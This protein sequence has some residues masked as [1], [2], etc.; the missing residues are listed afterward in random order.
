M[1]AHTGP[2][3]LL[4]SRQV[5]GYSL[6]F[7]VYELLTRVRLQY[8]ATWAIPIVGGI[9]GVTMWGLYYPLDMV[10]SRSMAQVAATALSPRGVAHTAPVGQL[11]RDI[12]REGGVQAFYR[13]VQPAV[14]PYCPMLGLPSCA[15]HICPPSLYT[16]CESLL[17]TWSCVCHVRVCAARHS[18][19]VV[20]GEEQLV[21]TSL[22]SLLGRTIDGGH[23]FNGL[24]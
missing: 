24:T 9:A 16:A 6:Y 23:P 8:D 13:G 20:T 10:K 21:H 14:R 4:L 18:H 3:L 5:P 17:C 12:Y 19:L 2:S 15:A 22:V 11:F 1:L 7:T